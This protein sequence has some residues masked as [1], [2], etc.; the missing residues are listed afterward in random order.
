MTAGYSG[1]PLVKKLGIKE[2]YILK[3]VNE[4]GNYFD[5]L[6]GLPPSV[7]IVQEKDTDIDCIHWFTTSLHDLHVKLPAYMKQIKSNGM[8]WIS[9][10]KKTSKVPTDITEDRIRDE[11]L[12]LGLVDV[13]VCAVDDTWSALK[14]V[15]RLEN[16]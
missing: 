15:Y 10:P 2:N 13:K 11:A 14:L 4:P 9:W 8:I 7:S 6:L 1:T 16:R 12:P 3:P 5:L